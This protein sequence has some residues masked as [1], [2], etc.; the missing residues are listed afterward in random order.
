MNKLGMSAHVGRGWR[1]S[2]WRM[3]ANAARWS[4]QQVG[5]EVSSL[6]S[7]TRTDALLLAPRPCLRSCL[8]VHMPLAQR[9][10]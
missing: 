1:Q 6:R 10:Q 4:G 7:N 8:H 9:N 2:L 3:A 5:A